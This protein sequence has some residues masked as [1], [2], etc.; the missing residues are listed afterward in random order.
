MPSYYRLEDS[1]GSRRRFAARRCSRR[2]KI[3]DVVAYLMTLDVKRDHGRKRPHHARELLAGAAPPA[4]RRCCRFRPARR[5]NARDDAGRD[6]RVIGEAPVNKGKVTLDIPPLVENGNTVAMTVAVESPMTADGPRQG[7]PRLQREEP[8]AQC[9]QRLFRPARRPRR[10]LDPH[11][12]R[13]HPERRRH[14]RDER[15]LVLVRQRRRDRH[16]RG[17]PGVQ[18]M[19]ARTL[20]NVPPKAKRGQVIEI[21]TL[22]SHIMETGYRRNATGDADPARHHQQLRLPLQRRRDLPRRSV[23]RRSRPIRSSPSSRSR[24]RAERFEF[25]LDRRP[26]RTQVQPPRSPSNERAVPSVARLADANRHLPAGQSER[27]VRLRIAALRLG[28]LAQRR[29]RAAADFPNRAA[30]TADLSAPTPGRCRT[31]TP[32]IPACCRCSTARRCGTTRPARP[33]TPAPTATAMRH[34]A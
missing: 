16:A 5:G 32:P 3:E 13:R 4:R 31:T 28:A 2:S 18:L 12:P 33:T 6:P 29:D 27:Q 7:D 21:K 19:M 22:I 10:L 24:P 23:S 15:R 17:L 25:K 30:R 26:R 9:H 34:R 20:I 14:R 8:A 11:P 1:N